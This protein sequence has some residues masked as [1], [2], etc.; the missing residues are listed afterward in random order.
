MYRVEGGG[1]FS[2]M[3][4]GGLGGEGHWSTEACWRRFVFLRNNNLDK[5]YYY[6]RTFGQSHETDFQ[7]AFIWLTVIGWNVRMGKK[8]SFFVYAEKF[9]LYDKFTENFDAS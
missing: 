2:A 6:T 3:A 1:A 8:F 7:R 4:G 9:I 5:N